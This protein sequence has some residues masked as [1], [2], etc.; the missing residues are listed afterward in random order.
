MPTRIKQRFSIHFLWRIGK[1]NLNCILCTNIKYFS[2]SQPSQLWNN[3]DHHAYQAWREI[4]ISEIRALNITATLSQ[5]STHMF[6]K[7]PQCNQYRALYG[8][9]RDWGLSTYFIW[10]KRQK[11]QWV[12]NHQVSRDK[13]SH[14][15]QITHDILTVAEI[16][17]SFN[18]RFCGAD[19]WDANP[20]VAFGSV[21]LG[22]RK[23][24][25]F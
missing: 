12:T 10:I 18:H 23:V 14:T 20:K 17:I 1:R 7:V 11:W 5:F 13:L 8:E 19:D 22:F 21:E 3:T 16:F 6:E 4:Y 25:I 9:E 2:L 24:I 15:L